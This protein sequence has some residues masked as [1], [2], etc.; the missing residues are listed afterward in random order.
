MANENNKKIPCGGFYLGDGLTMDG[1][2]LKSLGGGEQVQTDWNQN[3]STAKDY[4]KNRP[5]G[6]E[7]G[8]EITWDGDTTGR[9]SAT[10]EGEPVAWY[11]V[12]DKIL[13]AD[14]IIGGTI[15]IIQNGVSQSLV[16]T[17]DIVV[18][19]DYGVTMSDGLIILAAQQGTYV[20]TEG[21]FSISI[22]ETG[23]YFAYMSSAGTTMYTSSGTTMYT[24][25]LS[26]IIIHPFDDKYIPDTIAR[27]DEVPD[28]SLGV[29]EGAVK[30]LM[31]VM[32]VDGNGRPTAWNTVTPDKAV[33][34]TST[35]KCWMLGVNDN[36][37][38]SGID[39]TASYVGINETITDSWEEII[40]ACADGTYGTKYS[41]G[42][43]KLL[44][45]G[46]EGFV[47]MQIAAFDADTL[48]D[49]SGK[50][51]ISWISEQLLK[52]DHRM[53]PERVQNDDGTYQEGTGGI[54]GWEK[55]EMRSYLIDTI[56]PLIPNSVSNAIKPVT[57][58]QPAYNTSGLSFTQTT[59]DDVWIPS[60]SE[61]FRK[62]SLYYPL[63]Q[64]TSANRVKKKSGSTSDS[65]WWL[66]SA[67]FDSGFSDVYSDGGNGGDDSYGSHGVALGFCT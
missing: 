27:K 10:A 40:A 55:S 61:M 1:N 54:G 26:S 28:F 14:D 15:T 21:G 53:N 39:I 4:I 52:T 45:L 36:G 11:K 50:A 18:R 57:K 29:S 3:D 6:Y 43:T 58:T 22:P 44:N 56:K 31:Q 30:N 49:G 5:G 66:R 41:V 16:V 35:S 12:S 38:I 37:D 32:A 23:V 20:F 62:S 2:T 48:A 60:Y 8:F 42:D 13:T 7:E 9:V 25:S 59:T 46:S 24:S 64:N 47:A 63:F 51:P 67:N 33:V 19:E 17:S 65:I 34:L